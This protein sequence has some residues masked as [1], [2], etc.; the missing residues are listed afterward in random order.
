[1][2]GRASWNFEVDTGP[3]HKMFLKIQ[4]GLVANA[5]LEAL[6]DESVDT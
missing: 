3:A 6:E 1:M 2:I 5:D 4:A